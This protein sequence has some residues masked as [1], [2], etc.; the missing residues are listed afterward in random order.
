MLM[1]PIRT[2]ILIGLTFVGGVFFERSNAQ[3]TCL[4]GGGTWDKATCYGLE[5]PND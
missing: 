1:R 5:T 3:T 2:L 4:D